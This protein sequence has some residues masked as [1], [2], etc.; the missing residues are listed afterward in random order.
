MAVMVK[1]ETPHKE[2]PIITETLL[3]V[4]VESRNFKLSAKI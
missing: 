4:E 3:K 1:K 2:Y